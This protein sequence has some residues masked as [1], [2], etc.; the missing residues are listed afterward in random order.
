MSG[1]TSLSEL[2]NQITLETKEIKGKQPSMLSQKDVEEM[3]SHLEGGGT[4]LPPQDIPVNTQFA[5]PDPQARPEYIPP[6]LQQQAVQR[7]AQR[8]QEVDYIKEHD[9]IENAIKKNEENENKQNSLD[10]LYDE[11][12]T[13][14][15][16]M[17]L[18]FIFQMPFFQK[19]MIRYLPSLFSKDGHPTFGGFIIKTL[20]FGISFYGMNKA[21]FFLSE[22]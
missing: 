12:Q 1:T 18:F 20:L 8:V 5:R 11:I 21:I 13:P 14:L 6:P 10:I 17:L 4:Q 7:E 16:V 9:T 19:I 15:F 2:P 22:V 3:V